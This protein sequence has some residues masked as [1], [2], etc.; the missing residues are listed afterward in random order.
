MRKAGHLSE[1]WRPPVWL[2]ALILAPGLV[3]QE[4]E[5]QFRKQCMSCHTIGAG[6]KTGPDL[7]NLHARRAKDWSLSFIQAPGAAIDKGDA[8][9]LQLLKEANNVKMPDLGIT[10]AEADALLR[11]IEDYS[12][13]G[14]TLG[15]AGI[16]RPAT[17]ADLAN[18]KALFEGRARLAKGGPSCLSCHSAAGAGILGGGRLG[19]DLTA[20][21][22]KYGKGLASAIENPAFPSM[23][24]AFARNGLTQEEAFQIAAYLGSVSSQPP[25]RKDAIFPVLGVIGMAGGLALGSRM[26]RKRFRGV[27][28]NLEPK[29]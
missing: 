28:Q 3:A 13:A 1:R 9:A 12:K 27:R 18:G 17:A 20:A 19:P 25:A 8:T 26:G 23:Q 5:A 6:P 24:G 29:A 4:A 16:T 10:A 14:K 2:L 7:K 21:A 11:L 22:G 15:S